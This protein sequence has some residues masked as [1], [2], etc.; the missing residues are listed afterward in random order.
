M[1]FRPI[2]HDSREVKPKEFITQSIKPSKPK[3]ICKILEKTNRHK[4]KNIGVTFMNPKTNLN[5]T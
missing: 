4:L 3:S 1:S 2:V 5:K